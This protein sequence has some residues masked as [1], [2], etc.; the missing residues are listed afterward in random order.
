MIVSD[1]TALPAASWAG[2]Y[3]NPLPVGQ[4]VVITSLFTSSMP[5]GDAAFFHRL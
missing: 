2:V 1:F 4:P 5:I 3:G